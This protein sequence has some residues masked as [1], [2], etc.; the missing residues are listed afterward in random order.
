MF[1]IGIP[2]SANTYLPKMNIY[3]TDKGN[4]TAFFNAAGLANRGDSFFVFICGA[5]VMNFA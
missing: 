2:H 1:V 4:T 3:C 5:K